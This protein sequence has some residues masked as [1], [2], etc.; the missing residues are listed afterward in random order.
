MT[1]P[2]LERAALLVIDVQRG[3]CAA[4]GSMARSGGDHVLCAAVVP[5]VGRLTAGWR[6]SGR[7]VVLTRY[8]LAADGGDAGLLAGRSP[9]LRVAGAL[10]DGTPDAEL[11]PELTPQSDDL[12]L[13]KTRFSAFHATDLAGHLRHR[14]VDT[15]VVCGVTTNVCVDSTVRDAF[16]RD[17]RVVVVADA[18]AS[19]HPALHDASLRTIELCMGEVTDVDTVLRPPPPS[20]SGGAA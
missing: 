19:T 15:V 20:A 12:V 16:A 4:D 18:C 1:L 6:A 11:L 3:F 9:Q 10:V 14:G 8:A 13:T 17:L 2:P 5:A 7:P